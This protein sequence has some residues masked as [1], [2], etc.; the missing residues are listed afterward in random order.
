MRLLHAKSVKFQEFE[1]SNIPHYA[2]LSHRWEGGE[3]TYQDMQSGLPQAKK[4]KGFDKIEQ[5]CRQAISDGLEY[6][7]VDTC[8]PRNIAHATMLYKIIGNCRQK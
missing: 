8:C 1:G 3:V 2:I 7:W 4:K 6:V 5:S